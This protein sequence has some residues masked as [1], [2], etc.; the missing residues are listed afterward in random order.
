MFKETTLQVNRICT[1]LKIDKN[2]REDCN[3]KEEEEAIYY[4]PIT[5]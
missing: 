5:I 2:E 1:Q 3:A 4:H